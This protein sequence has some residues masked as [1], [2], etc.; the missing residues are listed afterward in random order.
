MLVEDVSRY[1][2]VTDD[3]DDSKI[4]EVR[5]A[6]LKVVMAKMPIGDQ[7][8]LMMKYLDGMSIKEISDTMD[9]SES[10]IKMKLKRA[11][12]RFV[13]IHQEANIESF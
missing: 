7:S 6:N 2:E 1:E 8:V 12:H 9:K 4:L 3:I 5:L 13:K 11:K 10:A